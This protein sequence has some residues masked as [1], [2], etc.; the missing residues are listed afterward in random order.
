MI[1][2]IILYLICGMICAG[3][4]FGLYY[5]IT[6]SSANNTPI[7]ND[8][9]TNII[10]NKNDNKQV[11]TTNSNSTIRVVNFYDETMFKGKNT[12]LFMWASWCP[13]CQEE[14]EALDKILKKYKNDEN[15]NIVFIAHEF[16]Q[17]DGNIDSLLSLLEGGTVDFNTEILLDFGRV[18]RKQIDP[19]EGYIPR[20]YFLDKNCNVLEEVTEPVTVELV[21]NLINKYYKA[22]D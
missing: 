3:I 21:E 4:A 2:K 16:E 22:D 9:N 1:K 8:N 12:V 20:T 6:N 11:I 7:D 5:Y 18:I 14:F 17:T 10:L 19:E 13:N 15:V